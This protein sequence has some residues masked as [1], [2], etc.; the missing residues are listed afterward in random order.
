MISRKSRLIIRLV[1]YGVLLSLLGYSFFLHK[2]AEITDAWL[3]FREDRQW[4]AIA[5]YGYGLGEIDEVRVFLLSNTRKQ[6]ADREYDVSSYA[7]STKFAVNEAVLIGESAQQLAATW[8]AVNLYAGSTAGC[9]EP[10]H[11]LQFRLRGSIVAE[12]VI[13]FQCGNATL[14]GFPSRAMVSFITYERE[15]K[16]QLQALKHLVEDLAGAG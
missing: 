13:C 2:K 14:P 11:V 10:R 15:S 3:K 16:N 5:R 1:V 12:C 7:P 8:R 6:A 9:F 4:S